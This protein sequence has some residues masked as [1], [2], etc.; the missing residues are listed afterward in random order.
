[1]DERLRRIETTLAAL[2]HSVDA[3]NVRLDRLEQ[4]ILTPVE[5]N[6]PADALWPLDALGLEGP[7]RQLASH[8]IALT[9][10]A[11]LALA[12]AYFLRALTESGTLPPLAGIIAGLVYA[13]VWF[14]WA[15]RRRTPAVNAAF[16]AT[17]ACAIAFPLA[18]EAT[19]K[20]ALL[21]AATSALL[22]CVVTGVALVVASQRRLQSIAWVATLAAIGFAVAFVVATDRV[23]PYIAA[24]IALGIVTLWLGYLRDWF[25]LRWPVA[26]V[27]DMLVAGAAL[28]IVSGNVQESAARVAAVALLL[29][30][31]Y[32]VN[33]IVRTVVR[34]RDV[35][36]F[37]VVQSIAALSVGLGCVVTVA[38]HATYGMG[39]IGWGALALGASCYAVAFLFIEHRQHSRPNLYFY[40]S[41]GLL[42]VLV[43][44]PLLVP[45]PTMPY[46]ILGVAAAVVV[47][48]SSSPMML[49]HALAY[50]F[51]AVIASAALPIAGPRLVGPTSPWPPIT[52]S[53]LLAI[54]GAG[55]TYVLASRAHLTRPIIVARFAVLVLFVFGAGG[56]FVNLTALALAVGPAGL[57]AGVVATIRTVV[58]A[59]VAVVAAALARVDRIREIGW[60][61]YP[62]LVWG[63]IKLIV[64]D[65]PHSRPAT[66]FLALAVFGLA[67]I[68]APR[69]T[70]W[71]VDDM[72][73][74]KPRPPVPMPN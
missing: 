59:T 63:G 2:Q 71:R 38:R 16:H 10:A 68:A 58:I 52:D 35:I 14:A 24:M 12:G 62:L 42:L 26:L 34:G 47:A 67:L 28:R 65:I 7:T 40:T 17:V 60:L 57:D 15:D 32:L 8:V 33:I 49:L 22:L 74:G 51:A 43:S 41:I 45:D 64:D 9:G 50:T 70:R 48:R 27:A 29:P 37:E 30:A 56:W 3:L 31:A 13:L 66:L 61:V 21:T 5:P 44:A 72:P 18:W 11:L 25:F 55:V 36:P 53:M 39:A 4:G 73:G 69:L 46:A 6:S 20:F 1:M 19:T 23:L 54:A